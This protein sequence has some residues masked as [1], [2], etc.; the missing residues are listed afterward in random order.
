M[1]AK[2]VPL[3]IVRPNKALPV[4]YTFETY[5]ADG[6]QIPFRYPFVDIANEA[7]LDDGEFFRHG[8]KQ[9]ATTGSSSYAVDSTLGGSAT[10]DTNSNL[11]YHLPRTEKLIL[12]V[13]VNTLV[14]AA[15]VV[16]TIKGSQEYRID[17]FTFSVPAAAA[18]GD[19]FEIP[20]Y[21]FGLMIQRD[22]GI[23]DITADSATA[24]DELHLD[25]ALVAR[26]Y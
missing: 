12:L 7:D 1:A 3:T 14:G 6:L 26:A 8:L 20:L 5:T 21:D 25:F 22:S 23:I 10:A 18:V 9:N 19:V 13:K 11:G 24:D 15:P 2:N 4:K 16:V 17:D